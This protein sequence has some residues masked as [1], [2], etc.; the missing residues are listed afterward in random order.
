MPQPFSSS[1]FSLIF[2]FLFFS[3]FILTGTRRPSFH[4][5]FFTV[6][7]YDV[8]IYTRRG[9][10]GDK[11][12]AHTGSG[13]STRILHPAGSRRPYNGDGIHYI[14]LP[15]LNDSNRPLRFLKRK[16]VNKKLNGIEIVI[17]SNVST[18][19]KKTEQLSPL[20][21]DV[22]QRHK[23]QSLRSFINCGLWISQHSIRNCLFCLPFESQTTFTT[24]GRKDSTKREKSL[25]IMASW[26][27]LK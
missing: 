2:F 9:G 23:F 12:H 25:T 15:L 6:N 10:T 13:I 7:L 24:M 4:S 17:K 16:K 22:I 19:G 21:L 3:S 18:T 5:S 8:D 27:S 11:R 26:G 20:S 14:V 1:S